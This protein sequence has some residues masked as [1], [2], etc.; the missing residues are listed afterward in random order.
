MFLSNSQ[1]TFLKVLTLIFFIQIASVAA[2]LI[3]TFC[4]CSST[5]KATVK[6][7]LQDSIQVGKSVSVADSSRS[8]AFS[9]FIFKFDSLASSS[10]TINPILDIGADSTISQ[11]PSNAHKIVIYGGLLANK[12][13]T[14]SLKSSLVDSSFNLKAGSSSSYDNS[15]SSSKQAISS[16]PNFFL[17]FILLVLG[18]LLAV[19]GF[20]PTRKG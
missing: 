18:F 14:S 17:L 20:S 13:L 4:S 3:I 16:T 11:T 5:K 2:V 12:S 6:T 9:D 1:R 10:P 15:N 19:V 7:A 8:F